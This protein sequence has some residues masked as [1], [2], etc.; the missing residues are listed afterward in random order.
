MVEAIRP[1][2]LYLPKLADAP[3]TI[4]EHLLIRFPNVDPATWRSRVSQG[5][6][7]LSD[8]TT[9][10]EDSPY[11]HG[12][13]VFYRKHVASEPAPAEEPLIVYRD[14]EIIIADKPHGIPVTPAGAYV[15]RSLLALLQKNNELP[16]LAAMHR[17][18]LETAGLLLLTIR[19]ASRPHYHRLFAERTI[20][21]E[22]LALARVAVPPR[23]T[24]WRIETRIAPGEPWFRQHIVDGATNAITDIEL[25]DVQDGIGR[26][27]LFPS[28]GRKHQLRVH[29]A[30]IGYPIL[31]DPLYPAITTKNHTDPPLQLL[32]RRLA[33]VDP[34]SG[35][36]RSFESTRKLEH[37][38][39][40]RRT[41]LE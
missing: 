41:R 7:T 24:R 13:T 5:L 12:L 33:F 9:L 27:R 8:G 19:P 18:D 25:I 32:A 15:E 17:L 38:F 22:Y 39:S 23:Q 10:R 30:S 3:S 31:G 2:R 6:V 16:D 1:S 11:R 29:M 26:F 35:A 40:D 28:T 36:P 14:D 37:E 20:E 21:R 4:F 34:L